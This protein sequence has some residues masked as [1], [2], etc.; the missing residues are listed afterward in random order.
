M[1][2]KSFLSPLSAVQR[3]EFARKCQTTKGHLQNVM[4]GKS[5]ATDLAVHI[6]RES[7]SLVTRKELRE[8]WANH[9]PELISA[10]GPRGATPPA[11]PAST[12][13]GVI[14]A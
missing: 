3:E 11:A 6:E 1:D 10:E 4:Y 12:T 13:Q 8:D 9:W 14:N 5:C 2:L 7:N